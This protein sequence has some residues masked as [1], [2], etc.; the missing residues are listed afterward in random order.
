[1][2]KLYNFRKLMNKYSVPFELHRKTD[3]KYVSGRWEDGTVE[4]ISMKGAIVPMSERKIYHSGGTYTTEDRELYV[5][6]ELG[7]DLT[8]LNVVYKGNTYTVETSRN[9]EDYADVYIYNLKWVGAG[10]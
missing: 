1:M 7:F 4:V 3:G 6:E 10:K 8:S 5:S 9:F 2:S